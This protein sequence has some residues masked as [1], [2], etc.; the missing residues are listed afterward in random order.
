MRFPILACLILGRACSQVP[1]A[2][3]EPAALQ[4]AVQ[5]RIMEGLPYEYQARLES[6]DRELS[7][8]PA[9]IDGQP[10]FLVLNTLKRWPNNTTVRVAFLGGSDDLRRQITTIA[11]GWLA[12]GANI[13]L[14]FGE[15]G[16]GHFRSWTVTDTKL[17]AD[18]RVS[19]NQRGYW[20]LVGTD[21]NNSAVIS[22]NMA[23]MNLQSF[24]TALPADWAGVVRHEFGH[25]LGFE[26][27]HQSSAGS[28]EDVFR[29]ADDQGYQLTRDQFGQ[30]M[31]DAEHRRPG[32]YT[33]L[34]N[35]P[36]Y[37]PRDMVDHNLRRLPNSSAYDTGTFDPKS[38][39]KYWFPSWMFKDPNN[40]CFTPAANDDFSKQD[41]ARMIA[42]YPPGGSNDAHKHEVLLQSLLDAKTTPVSLRPSFEERVD[43]L[44]Q[45]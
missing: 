26:H 9:T 6:R 7:R 20:S 37:W 41:L 42:I 28:C 32:I 25:A 1:F 8:L 36:N 3:D 40:N 14:D 16:Q 39:M 45:K 38:I 24:D 30:A 15:D 22:P 21:S 2:L 27:E 31:E 34:G 29:W 18:V 5:P 11:K 4:P 19:F 23:S 12:T 13:K 33:V 10:A 43:R 35:A 17:V 44:K